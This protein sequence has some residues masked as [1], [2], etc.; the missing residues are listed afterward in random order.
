MVINIVVPTIGASGGIDVI[1]KYV[2]LF[3]NRGH[4]VCVYKELKASNMHRYK[5]KTKNKIHQG[6]CTLK[7]IIMRNR[8]RNDVDKFV[9][10][11]TNKT[12]R[13]AD[14][15]IATAWPT[16]FTIMD[17]SECKGK[18]FYFIQDY[19]KWDNV[20]YVKNSY[21]L[22]LK[23]IVISGWINNCLKAD[24]G[25]GPFPIVHNGIDMN[26]YHS[27]KEKK[28]NE[29][30]FLMLNHKLTKKGVKYGLEVFEI[31]KDRIPNCKL[32]M[33]GMCDGLNLPEYVEY[34]QNPSKYKI[35]ELYSKSKFFIF[36][37]LEE[38]WGLTPLEAMACGCI[39]FGTSTG[40][41]IDIGVNNENV[42]IS[43]PKDVEGMVKNIERC[44]NNLELCEKILKNSYNLVKRLDW[45]D[46]ADKLL[47]YLKK[48]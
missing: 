13:N 10:K 24:L 17:L 44:I 37:S 46:S 47:Y 35:I 36:P 25:I 45:N 28:S 8:Y 3:I 32:R 33:F 42:M 2:E 29:N 12:V 19:E 7:S 22:P 5:S 40:F 14:V 43:A 26:I 23:K 18:K 9:W 41:I 30:S 31:I 39:V 48:E 15:I 20:E 4:D 34:Y 27:N 21:K 11:I 6:Y 16:S 1:Y 38:G